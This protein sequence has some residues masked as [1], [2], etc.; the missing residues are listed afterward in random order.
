MMTISALDSID[1]NMDQQLRVLKELLGAVDECEK[2]NCLEDISETELQQIKDYCADMALAANTAKKM[3][4]NLR[5]L[6]EAE[7]KAKKAE[8]KKKKAEAKK[9]ETAAKKKA[10]EKPAEQGNS[11]EVTEEED[12]SFLD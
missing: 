12:L 4:K 5:P 6:A 8:E 2:N 9:T 1:R 7:D 11:P 10:A 3:A